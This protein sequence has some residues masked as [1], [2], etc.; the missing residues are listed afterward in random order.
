MKLTC[1]LGETDNKVYDIVLPNTNT[2]D[3]DANRLS[4]GNFY[5]V[6]GKVSASGM[7]FFVT[8]RQWK[9]GDRQVIDF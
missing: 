5:D 1:D 9:K 4:K 8:V 2:T 3:A 6:I 7:E